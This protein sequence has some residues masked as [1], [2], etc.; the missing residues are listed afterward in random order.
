MLGNRRAFSLQA[1]TQ[2]V[3]WSTSNWDRGRPG[4]P[5]GAAPLGWLTRPHVAQKS[6]GRKRFVFGYHVRAMAPAIPSRVDLNA[7]ILNSKLTH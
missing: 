5:G 1:V 6:F 7:R 3:E 2:L 4:A